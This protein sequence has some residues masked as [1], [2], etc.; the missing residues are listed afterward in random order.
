MVSLLIVL[1]FIESNSILGTLSE[2]EV[3]L[4]LHNEELQ[5]LAKG[6]ALVHKTS[7]TSFLVTGL[8]LEDLQYVIHKK[9][10]AWFI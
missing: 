1:L 10:C 3:R 7:A 4:C 6:N 8:E 2:S 9:S 5:E